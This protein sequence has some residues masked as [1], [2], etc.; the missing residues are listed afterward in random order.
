MLLENGDIWAGQF[1]KVTTQN[2]KMVYHPLI[3]SARQVG[4]RKVII[5]IPRRNNRRTPP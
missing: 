3:F 4:N 1:W 2:V 5:I